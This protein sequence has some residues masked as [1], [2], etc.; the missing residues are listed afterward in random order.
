[1]RSL[2]CRT[3]LYIYREK[4]KERDLATGVRFT[5]RSFSILAKKYLAAIIKAR[6]SVDRG[7]F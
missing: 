6:I 4:E 7:D 1:M 3:P 2:R 5:N